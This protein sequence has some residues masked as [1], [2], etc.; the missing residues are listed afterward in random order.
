MPH[1]WLFHGWATMPI[2]SGDSSYGKHDFVGVVNQDRGGGWP[3]LSSV[4]Q[5]EGTHFSVTERNNDAEG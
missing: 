3:R 4:R 2:V 5:G 1:P